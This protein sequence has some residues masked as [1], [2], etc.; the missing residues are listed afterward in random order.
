MGRPHTLTATSLL[1]RAFPRPAAP[2]PPIPAPRLPAPSAY[3]WTGKP[4]FGDALNPLLLDWFGDVRPRRVPAADADVIVCGSVLEHLP[5]GW[6][7]IVAGA[8]KMYEQT[9][10]DSRLAAATVL[11]LRGPLSAKGV[12][13]DYALG[14]PGLLACELV[15]VDDVDKVYNLGIVPHWS[16]T[17]LEH[18][19]EF[20]GFSPRIIRPDGD[21]LEVVAEI[22]RCRKVVSSSL[23]GLIV[24]DAFGIPRRTEVAV[25]L[26]KEGGM[27]KF[28]DHCAAV[29]VPF[30]VGVTQLAPRWIVERRQHEI[31]DVLASVGRRLMGAAR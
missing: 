13:G 4:N 5:A 29:G 30:E 1:R 8:G 3:W 26:E 21:P 27:F 18:R 15:A 23:H 10:L 28:R 17:T 9:D 31:Y 12:P 20:K 6:Q 22:G 2:A 16:D 19:H 11:A 24:A 25:R 7:G 14:D